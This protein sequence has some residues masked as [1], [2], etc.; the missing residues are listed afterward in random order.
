MKLVNR[1]R[2]LESI[3]RGLPTDG[4]IIRQRHAVYQMRMDLALLE[5]LV[6]QI[7]L[8]TRKAESSKEGRSL[9]DELEFWDKQKRL[10]SKQLEWTSKGSEIH[11]KA[12]GRLK[13]IEKNKN[14]VIEKLKKLEGVKPTKDSRKAKSSKKAKSTKKS[15]EKF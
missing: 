9:L 6:M 12:I 13:S 1:D 14:L 3:E 8:P 11:N 15:I 10:V 2:L 7:G 5:S 4:N